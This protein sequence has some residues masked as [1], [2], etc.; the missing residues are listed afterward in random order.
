MLS[1]PQKFSILSGVI[2]ILVSLSALYFSEPSKRPAPPPR[3]NFSI[4]AA[5]SSLSKPVAVGGAGHLVAINTTPSTSDRSL[6][7]ELKELNS[8][9][10]KLEQA[11]VKTPETAL[12]LPL[13][14]RDLDAMKEVVQASNT[15]FKDSVDR[16]YDLNKWLLGT[17]AV[18]VIGLAITTFLKPTSKQ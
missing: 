17:M 3:V 10:E 4:H 1:L 6:A 15:Y 11:V 5:G 18:S 9:L 12:A 2:G 7:P 13:L 8:R 14:R 16:I